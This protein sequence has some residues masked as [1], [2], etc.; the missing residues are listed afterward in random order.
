MLL[1]FSGR[2]EIAA[3]LISAGAEI[4]LSD[5]HYG[6]PLHAVCSMRNPNLEC[7]KILIKAGKTWL[8]MDN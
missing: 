2:A 7:I 3:I 1:F 5:L 4:N 6:T 8:D